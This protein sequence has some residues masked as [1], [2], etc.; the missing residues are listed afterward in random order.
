MGLAQGAAAKNPF[1]DTLAAV[2]NDV[3]WFLFLLLVT[4]FGWATPAAGTQTC[5]LH[6]LAGCCICLL[7]VHAY[8]VI[9]TCHDD[10][11]YCLDDAACLQYSLE[12]LIDS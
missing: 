1:I 7:V 5:A 11:A 6:R 8:P 10:T 4:M 12:R 3:K 9:E 2:L